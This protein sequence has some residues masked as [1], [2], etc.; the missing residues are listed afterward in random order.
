MD[1]VERG[2]LVVMVVTFVLFGTMFIPFIVT[3]VLRQTV[4]PIP[5]LARLVI[6]MLLCLM[7]YLGRS[8]ARWLVVVYCGVFG[9][10]LIGMAIQ[11]LPNNLGGGIYLLVS[12]ITFVASFLTLSFAPA[13]RVFFAYQQ[14]DP[15]PSAESKDV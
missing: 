10:K 14:K 7:M 12:G 2:R 8:W 15:E 6:V 4:N 9:L 13:V 3:S 5:P 11:Q 1:H